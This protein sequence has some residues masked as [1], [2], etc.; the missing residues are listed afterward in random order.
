MATERIMA[1]MTK[2]KRSLLLIVMPYLLKTADFKDFKLRSFKAFPY[3]A[4]SIASYL[5]AKTGDK[6]AIE[7]LDCNLHNEKTF[8]PSWR[9]SCMH[10][11]RISWGSR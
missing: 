5:K 3:G 4:L 8:S 11:N 7:L 1:E 6:A 2:S 9:R 10:S